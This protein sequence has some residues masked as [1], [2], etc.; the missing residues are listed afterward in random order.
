LRHSPR[1]LDALH[2]IV[3]DQLLLGP[4]ATTR[5]AK[6]TAVGYYYPLGAKLSKELV[7][8]DTAFPKYGG[9]GSFGIQGVTHADDL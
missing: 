8:E 1:L 5:S 2:R 4:I 6:D 9:I 7:L 3:A